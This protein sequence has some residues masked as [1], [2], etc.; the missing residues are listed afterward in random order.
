MQEKNAS[1]RLLAE[2][3]GGDKTYFHPGGLRERTLRFAIG[4]ACGRVI[5]ENL[6]ITGRIPV[7]CV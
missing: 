7:V 2:N 4:M 3:A 6:R 1:G 5:V